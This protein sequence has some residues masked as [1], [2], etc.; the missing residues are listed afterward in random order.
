MNAWDKDWK[1]YS[2]KIV[3]YLNSDETY[4]RDPERDTSSRNAESKQ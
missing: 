1:A 2:D 4:K 3:K